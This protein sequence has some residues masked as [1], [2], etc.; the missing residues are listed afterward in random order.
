MRLLLFR[1]NSVQLRQGVAEWA[2]LGQ[3]KAMRPVFLVSGIRHRAKGGEFRVEL[4]GGHHVITHV[5]SDVS[6]ANG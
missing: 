5:I 3:Q 6:P 2:V 1:T 4:G